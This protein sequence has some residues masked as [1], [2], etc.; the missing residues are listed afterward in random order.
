L[1]PLATRQYLVGTNTMLARLTF[2][3]G[4]HV[5]MH[6][7]RHEQISQ[8]A[9]GALVF[10]IEGRDV[11]VRAGEILCIPPHVPHEV[12]ALEDSVA[13]D[14]FNPPREDWIA[15]DDAYLRAAKPAETA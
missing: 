6:A 15:G 5:P 9:E 11:T 3:T 2:K 8:V 13:L 4:G 7:H 12:T 10:G 1:N 14:I